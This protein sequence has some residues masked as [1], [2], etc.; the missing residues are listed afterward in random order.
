MSPARPARLLL[1]LAALAALALP[2]DFTA[3]KPQGYV[4]D[5]ARVL[6]PQAR[7]AL[8]DYCTRVEQATGAQIALVLLP[9]LDGQPIEDV[10]NLL[11]QR[12]GVGSKGKDEG[13]LL[14]IAI[15]DRRTRLEVG[16]GLEPV[17][18]DGFAGGVLRS[19]RDSLRAGDYPAA[20]TEAA[21][22]IG[23]A[24]A[25]EKNV[26]IS[27]APL[28][29]RRSPARPDD[30]PWQPFLVGLGVLAFLLITG[31]RGGRGGGP[32]NIL[33]AMMIGNAIGR[34]G[35]SR[36]GGGFGGYDSWGGG[37]GGFGGFGGGSSG[38][39]GASG[40]W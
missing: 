24:I 32:M 13:I 31:G 26:E 16:Y 30:A 11:F 37:G 25:R 18:P 15:A 5:F 29:R 10:A 39:G 9:S 34:S 27:G 28:A 4:S 33:L 21:T 8:D 3:L 7:A 36:G 6:S 35:G 40:S 20:L 17:V 1:L 19:M 12:W 2:A 22:T 23:T 14:L 38:G